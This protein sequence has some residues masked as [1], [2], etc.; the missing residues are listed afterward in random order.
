MK[1]FIDTN[2]WLRLLAADEK[3]L[4]QSAYELLSNVES[5]QLKP[6]TSTIV[7]L[8]IQYVLTSVYKVSREEALNDIDG[9]L[10]TRNITLI[11]ETYFSKALQLSREKRI[12][13]SDCL[14]YTQLPSE[15]ILCS[16]DKDFKKIDPL[17]CL[18]PVEVLSQM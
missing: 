18:T 3:S 4:Y 1:I 13:L 6:Y 15:A 8:E 16:F 9:V 17:R 7:L 2:V 5:A 14:I 12:K 10:S 11:E